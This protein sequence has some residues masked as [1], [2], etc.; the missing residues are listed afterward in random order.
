MVVGDS[1][2]HG[3]EGDYTWRFRIWEWFRDN[4]I[5]AEFVGPWPST[6]VAPLLQGT[7]ATVP[8]PRTYG[9]YAAGI[10]SFPCNHY[11]LWGRQAAQVKNDISSTYQPD[12]ILMAIG[13]N[14]MGWF[15]SGSEGTLASVK[16]IVDNARSAKPNR[17]LIKGRDDLPIATSN[18]NILLS[19][20]IPR[21]STPNSPLALVKLQENYG[22]GVAACPAAYDG[23]HPNALGEFQIAQAFSTTLKNSFGLGSAVLAIPGNIPGRSCSMPGNVRASSS[24]QG[25]TVTWDKVCGATGYNGQPWTEPQYANPVNRVDTSWTVA[26]LEWEYQIQAVCGDSIKSS[27]SGTVGATATPQTPEPPVNIVTHALS[28]GVTVSWDPAPGSGGVTIWE[29]ITYSADLA[30]SFLNSVG[31][32]GGARSAT[33]T[34]LIP[35]ER[36]VVAVAG[37]NQYGGGL[38][39]GGPQVRVGKG[40]PAAPTNL[41]V[42]TRDAVTVQLRYDGDGNAAGYHVWTRNVNEP[43]SVLKK[44]PYA[45]G[46]TCWGVTFLFPG[47][48]NYEYC[49]TAVNGNEESALSACVKGSAETTP[50]LL[51]CPAASQHDGGGWELTPEVPLPGGGGDDSGG[52][53]TL[54]PTTG[55]DLWRQD[56]SFTFVETWASQHHISF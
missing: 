6:P 50:G 17:T 51:E 56:T 27:Y 49:M 12:Y 37:W 1:I 28:N 9:G 22:C 30:G 26:G 34:G 7:K 55:D 48:W 23:L 35:G 10:G 19:Q 2:S 13:F 4:G 11:A 14:D 25:V 20:N 24:P 33:I 43:G 54:P 45:A 42:Y 41:K 46:S 5:A 31:I 8:P 39:G 47:V 15:V 3:R 53:P 44:D 16:S 38:P 32:P 36:Y 21:W 18:Y 40:R 52:M 29:V